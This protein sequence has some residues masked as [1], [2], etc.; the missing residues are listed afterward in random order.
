VA[1]E[2]QEAAVV[3]VAIFRLV[4]V[5]CAEAFVDEAAAV[6]VAAIMIVVVAEEP[7]HPLPYKNG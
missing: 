6:I 3:I 4:A 7:A 5:L 2:A 1:G